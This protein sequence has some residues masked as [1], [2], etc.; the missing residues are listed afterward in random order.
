M[1]ITNVSNIS[2]F[3]SKSFKA[4][5]ISSHT[6]KKINDDGSLS[7]FNADFVEFDKGNVNDVILFK[8]LEQ[9]S[10]DLLKNGDFTY[11]IAS[12]FLATESY[13]SSSIH[14]YGLVKPQPDYNKVNK[15][16]VLGLVEVFDGMFNPT[17][18]VDFIQSMQNCKYDSEERK[19]KEV[20]KRMLDGVIAETCKDVELSS[21]SSAKPFYIA[22]GFNKIKDEEDPDRMIYR[23]PQNNNY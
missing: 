12:N 2:N 20:G 18:N 16:N 6:I 4:N 10:K 23:N 1:Q 3:Y 13:Y 21:I 9:E 14:Y 5:K 8:N 11:W 19:F 7:D 17:Q 15:E 22:Y